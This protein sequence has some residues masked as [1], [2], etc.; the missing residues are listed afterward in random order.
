MS[1]D[2]GS[3]GTFGR[4]VDCVFHFQASCLFISDDLSWTLFLMVIYF[5]LL[6]LSKLVVS[7]LQRNWL[8]MSGHR[9]NGQ[10]T[11]I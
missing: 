10:T 4:A 1:E 3:L 11:E 6:I 8:D 5:S 7:H 9:L 2:T